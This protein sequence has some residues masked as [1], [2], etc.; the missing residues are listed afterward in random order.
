M[1]EL[2]R[3]YTRNFSRQ[4]RAAQLTAITRASSYVFAENPY[5]YSNEFLN[6]L[7]RARRRG[8]DVRVILP[9]ENDLAAGH[10]SNLVTANYLREQGVRVFLYP[11]M[12]HVKALLVDGWSCFGSA[13]F[14]ALSLRLN[15]EDDM[16]T[17]DPSF[18][19]RFR[20]DLF[21]VDFAKSRELQEKLPVGW[22]DHLADALLNPF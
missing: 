7:V 19:A 21:D 13:N 9:D 5:L 16:A 10:R 4:I 17:S 3:L 20:H 2:R 12:T 22:E 1:I 11:G 15:R 14:D 8:V 6:A 18:A